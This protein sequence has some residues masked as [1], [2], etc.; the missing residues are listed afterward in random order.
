MEPPTGSVEWP[1]P[2]HRYKGHIE[3]E[4]TEGHLEKQS[5]E[6]H[7]YMYEGH[8]KQIT[9][10]EFQAIADRFTSLEEVRKAIKSEGLEECGLIFG[11]FVGF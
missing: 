7:G 9:G 6:P 1:S 10:P 11:K 5:A 3:K 2:P 4:A 8:E